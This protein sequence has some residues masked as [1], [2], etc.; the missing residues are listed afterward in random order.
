MGPALPRGERHTGGA[1]DL[2]GSDKALP[3]AGKQ[4]FSA[5]RVELCEPLAERNAAQKPMEIDRLLPDPFGD[6][7]NRSETFLDCAQIKAGAADQN[8]QPPR[9]RRHGNRVECQ[10]TPER[11]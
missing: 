3:V 6:F 11:D 10:R 1:D 7:G 4:M 2:V 8:R 5:G 9:F